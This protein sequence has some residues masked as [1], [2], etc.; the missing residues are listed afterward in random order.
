MQGSKQ[1]RK[2]PIYYI[3]NFKQISWFQYHDIIK[4][5]S[6]EA[7]KLLDHKYTKY[8]FEAI[9]ES[10]YKRITLDEHIINKNI[11]RYKHIPL[12]N[13]FIKELYLNW[14]NQ[15]FV[16]ISVNVILIISLLLFL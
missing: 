7:A 5:Y 12:S 9:K 2:I 16:Y 4:N 1:K 13:P 8:E 14:F 10:V 3:R 15:P 11:Y 6:I